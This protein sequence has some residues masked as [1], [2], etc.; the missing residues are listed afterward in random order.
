MLLGETYTSSIVLLVVWAPQ[1]Y[2]CPIH[3][4][5]VAPRLGPSPPLP[6]ADFSQQMVSSGVTNMLRRA[7]CNFMCAPAAVAMIRSLLRVHDRTTLTIGA[8]A[9]SLATIFTASAADL[10]ER[11]IR[12]RDRTRTTAGM[13]DTAQSETSSVWSRHNSGRGGPRSGGECAFVPSSA[14]M[15]RRSLRTRRL[16][17]LLPGI[18]RP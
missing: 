17:R 9:R 8:P 2:F 6:L 1:H 16:P 13:P 15:K 11:H 3:P 10:S 5:R 12:A 7:G 4:R 18:S 14:I